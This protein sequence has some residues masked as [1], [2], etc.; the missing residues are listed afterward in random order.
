MKNIKVGDF[1]LEEIAE[2]ISVFNSRKF[3]IKKVVTRTT[4]TRINKEME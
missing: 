4:K 3:L 2:K 1:V